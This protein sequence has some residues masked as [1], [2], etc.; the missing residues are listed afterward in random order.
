[1]EGLKVVRILQQRVSRLEGF[2]NCSAL[3]ELW[4][5]ECEVRHYSLAL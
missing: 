3:Q 4:V 5:A 1:M 2:S